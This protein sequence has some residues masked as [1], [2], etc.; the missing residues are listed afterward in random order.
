MKVL[1][2]FRLLQ[3]AGDFLIMRKKIRQL[4]EALFHTFIFHCIPTTNT[5]KLTTK[6]RS[7]NHKFSKQIFRFQYFCSTVSLN[8][9]TW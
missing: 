9:G 2:N 8:S 7:Q 4:N 5:I 3:R 1:I 6:F